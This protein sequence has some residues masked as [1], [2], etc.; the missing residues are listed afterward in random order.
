MS[1]KTTDQQYTEEV[2]QRR[3]ETALRGARAVGHEPMKSMPKKRVET[4]QK[5]TGPKKRVPRGESQT[6]RGK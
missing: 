2:A 6:G 5:A 4:R 3:F 1:G